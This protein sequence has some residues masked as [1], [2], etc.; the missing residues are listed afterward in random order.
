MLDQG[1]YTWRHN[2][3]LDRIIMDTLTDVSDQSSSF[4]CDLAGAKKKMLVPQSP[5]TLCQLSRDL[6]MCSLTKAQNPLS[7]SIQEGYAG[8]YYIGPDDM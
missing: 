8:D 7:F 5:L 2:F 4:Y 6:M 3:A 1:R